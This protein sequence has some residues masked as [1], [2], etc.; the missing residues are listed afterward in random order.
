VAIH[1]HPLRSPEDTRRAAH[2]LADLLRPGD[3]IG[4]IGDLGAGKT[5]FVQGLARGLGV[6]EAVRVT[7]PTF[8]IINQHRGGRLALDHVDLY[9][10]ERDRELDE[11]GLDDLFR[12][13]SVVAVEWCDRFPVLPADH[14]EVRLQVTGEDTRALDAQGRG[15]RAAELAAAW[16]ARLTAG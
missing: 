4:L 15:A 1:D 6:P 3:V 7:S 5:C 14:L 2:A 13:G 12:G 8:T 16:A 9:R 10:I 11:I